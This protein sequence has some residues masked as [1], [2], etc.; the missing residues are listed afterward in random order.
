MGRHDSVVICIHSKENGVS[1]VDREDG[2]CEKGGEGLT[3]GGADEERR[4]RLVLNDVVQRRN[5][6][7]VA[8]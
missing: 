6:V 3:V 4:V 5:R 1:A 8:E 7:D 2:Q